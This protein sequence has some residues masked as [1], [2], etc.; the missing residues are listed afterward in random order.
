[1]TSVLIDAA[2]VTLGT[3]ALPFDEVREGTF[4]EGRIAPNPMLS[5]VLMYKMTPLYSQERR[6]S[7]SN[8]I[9]A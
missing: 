1:M 2:G 3:F 8:G 4:S 5:G 6:Y 9:F 7:Y